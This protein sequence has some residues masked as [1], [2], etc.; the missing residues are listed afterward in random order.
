[1]NFHLHPDSLRFG[2][3]LQQQKVE[4]ISIKW[5]EFRVFFLSRLRPRLRRFSNIASPLVVLG[6][7]FEFSTR[8]V[9]RTEAK[10]GKIRKFECSGDDNANNKALVV[11]REFLS[12]SVK[13]F[14]L[15]SWCQ[16]SSQNFIKLNWIKVEEKS[17]NNS[18][19]FT[20]GNGTKN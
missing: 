13:M 10:E 15:P 20:P 5:Q 3:Y 19:I 14:C 11:F 16:F 6:E 9:P 12:K 7:K 2:F 4:R 1:M 18:A 8:V 17:G